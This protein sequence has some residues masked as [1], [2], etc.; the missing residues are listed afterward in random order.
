MLY[1]HPARIPV[2]PTRVLQA[3][4]KGYGDV[5]VLALLHILR[6]KDKC[7]IMLIGH[8]PSSH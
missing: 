4:S 7:V 8:S 1:A 2:D 5:F 3:V 6:C